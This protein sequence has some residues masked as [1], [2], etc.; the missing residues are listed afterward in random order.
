MTLDEK[1][2]QLRFDAPPVKRLGVPAYN[3][4]NEGLHGVARGGTA[5]MFPQAIG[6]AAMFD[7]PQM[8]K[9]GDVVSTEFRAKYNEYYKHGD[10]DI[11][12][13]LTVWSPNINIFRDPRWGRGHETY[14]E[15]P[16]LTARTGVAYIRGLQ[17]DGPI[18][19]TSACAKHY[20][21]HSGP[22]GIRHSFDAVVSK[23]DLWETYLP[24]FEAAVTE[25]KVESVMGAYNRTNGEP[26]C[27]SKTLLV[28]ILRGKWGFK[29]HITSDCWAIKD[30][31]T[32]H[33]VTKTA[34]ESA[35]LA[36]ENGCDVNCG[37]TYLHMLTAYQEGLVT[38]EQITTACEHLMTTRFRLGL[39]DEKNPYDHLTFADSDTKEHHALSLKAAE[40]SMVLLKN[41]GILPLDKSKLRSVA[42]IGPTADN[43]IML[44]GNYFGT[45]S[46]TITLLEGIQEAVGEDVRVYY[47]EGCHLHKDTV[48]GLALPGDR[49]SE[50]V[51]MAEHSD[52]VFMCLGLDTSMEGEEGDQGNAYASGDKPDLL[53]PGYQQKLLDAVVAVGKPVVLLLC[54]GSALAID[55]AHEQCNAI[56]DVWYPGAFGGRAAAN[57]VFGETSPSGKLPLTFYSEKNTLPEFTDYAMKGR[58][59]RYIEE[60]PLYPFGYGLTYGDVNVTAMNVGTAAAGEDLNVTLTVKNSGAATKDALQLYIKNEDSAFAPLNPVLCGLAKV[61]L[62]AGEEKT[63]AITVSAAAFT[64]VN[65]EGERVLDGKN[66]TLYGGT[67][68]PDARTAALTGKTCVSIKIEL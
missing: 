64:V 25:A 58:T 2:S 44:A 66:F 35:A 43:R 46:K 60:E 28:D 42:V 39:F 37:N 22:E 16:F 29:G 11:Y 4:W 47:S 45:P 34:P 32:G 52:V 21:V 7:L 3:W 67:G 38:E 31:H 59:Y 53:L 51:I 19:K 61:E 36:L 13:G 33:F 6:M 5:T 9:I 50:A 55:K 54:G 57:I 49:V 15:D 56:L 63:V 26:C 20:A 65:D 1:A 18:L 8:Q 30:F 40:D 62:A 41:D 17:G 27:G 14:G 10:H 24:A 12:K 48:Q 68:Q 23:K